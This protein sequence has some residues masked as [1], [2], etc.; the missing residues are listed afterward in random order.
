MILT[1][2]VRVKDFKNAS[3]VSRNFYYIIRPIL[4]QEPKLVQRQEDKIEFLNRLAERDFPIKHLKS[5]S[6]EKLFIKQNAK[7]ISNI[8]KKRFHLIWFTLDSKYTLT[9]A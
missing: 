8:L 9:I 3:L 5:S 7:E 4:W 6:F 1:Y 2:L